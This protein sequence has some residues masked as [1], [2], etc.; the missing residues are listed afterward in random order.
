VHLAHL[1]H[2]SA[3]RACKACTSR[4][5]ASGRP[6]RCTSHELNALSAQRPCEVHISRTSRIQA[7]GRPGR[8]TSHA[9]HAFMCWDGLGGSP[10]T[11]LSRHV[12]C[13][14]SLFACSVTSMDKHPVRESP[15]TLSMHAWWKPEEHRSCLLHE[16]AS[17]S[18]VRVAA[19]DMAGA[20]AAA[21]LEECPC[22][23]ARQHPP[24]M[25]PCTRSTCAC[26]LCPRTAR[27]PRGRWT[28]LRPRT[29]RLQSP[30][31]AWAEVRLLRVRVPACVTSC[32]SSPGKESPP[33]AWAKVCVLQAHVPACL[34]A[35]THASLRG[36]LLIQSWKVH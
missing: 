34:T 20:L 16:R 27:L 13:F 15:G 19:A 3:Q 24:G 2:S 25:A 26:T 4:I 36:M 18:Y 17:L 32:S 31:T 29:W 10:G 35:R 33:A 23:Y 8:C 22:P 14:Q 11:R 12:S 9:H 21:W 5:Q 6:G 1:T 30:P 28:P 7:S